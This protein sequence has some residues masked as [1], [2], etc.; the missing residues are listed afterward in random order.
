MLQVYGIKN[1]NTVKKSL[2]W[3]DEKKIS[4]E[5]LDVKKSIIY[6]VYAD[7]MTDAKKILSLK[8]ILEYI[9]FYI[10]LMVFPRIRK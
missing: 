10:L 8:K 3:L 5:F 4:Y 7:D 6:R 2:T 1:C 9:L